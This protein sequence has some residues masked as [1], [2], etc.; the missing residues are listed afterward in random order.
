MKTK[1][2]Q[3]PIELDVHLKYLCES[4]G[5]TH[6]LSLRET[7]T[8]NFKVVCDCGN[9]FRVKLTKRCKIIYQ[10]KSIKPKTPAPPIPV[11]TKQTELSK[12]ILDQGIDILSRYG[13]TVAEAHSM[14]MDTYK[15]HQ[16]D[17]LGLLIKN[18]LASLGV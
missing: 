4:C 15:K 13:F 9:V 14:L 12:Q 7:S 17:D 10:K 16:T 11:Q 5:Q 3:K 8:K 18:S 6:W 2:I 1:S